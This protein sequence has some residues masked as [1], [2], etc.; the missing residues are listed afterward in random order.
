MPLP[1]LGPPTRPATELPFYSWSE[2]DSLSL[3]KQALRDM[4]F[5]IM[6]QASQI[7]D[8]MGR[9]DR[10]SGCL[11]TRTEA[12]PSLPFTMGV[13][14]DAPEKAEAIA[15]EA[16]KLFEDI[17]PNAELLKLQHWGVMLGIGLGQL[18]WDVRRVGT[19]IGWVPTLSIWHPRSLFYKLEDDTLHVQTNDGDVTVTPGDGQ[20]V[21]YAPYGLKR[22]WMYG[23]A[24]SLYV[25][26]LVRQWDWRDWARYN[27]V[28]GLPIKK[29]TTPFGADETDKQRFLKEVAKLG[30]ENTIRLP[31]AAN[32]GEKY[33]V[34]L[35]EALSNNY[36]TFEKL[37]EKADDAI[38]VNI[39]GQ[40]LTTSVKG[41][42]FAAAQVHENI[43]ASV[44]R[45]DAQNL[46]LCL[47]AQVLRPWCVYNHGDGELTPLPTW[48]TDPPEDKAQTGTAM[49]N[50]GE[51][52]TA[53]RNAGAN[54][55]VDEI[56]D[57]AG[58]S[59][60]G[61][62]EDV[63]AED[64]APEANDPEADPDEED[65]VG[66]EPQTHSQVQL[67]GLPTKTRRRLVEGQLYLDTVVKEGTQE[68]ALSLSPLMVQ[69][70]HAVNQAT[71][72]EDLKKRLLSIYSGDDRSQLADLMEKALVLAELEGRHAVLEEEP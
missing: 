48:S 61:P 21:V 71:S 47:R 27:E 52:I 49:K 30:S 28:H 11:L 41:G 70:L 66:E 64:V 17:C 39:L 51:G 53:L 2:W 59:T 23:K 68:S 31:K 57:R 25:P 15:M 10:I 12:L 42:S 69:L 56:L 44:L 38:A 33:D 72:Y 40:N 45:G 37:L 20:W 46:G 7:I 35:L 13:A 24:R 1:A 16:S 50:I 5:G 36:F 26:W 43:K 58:I 32:D 18:K 9:D 34:E 8:A 55:D 60:T 62:A 14:E 3:V 65:S 63:D 4:E 6:D 22:G 54:P 19:R 29:A 67:A